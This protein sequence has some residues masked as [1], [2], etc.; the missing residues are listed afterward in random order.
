[1]ASFETFLQM[2][3][4]ITLEHFRTNSLHSFLTTLPSNVIRG[5]VLIMAHII[6]V[7]ASTAQVFDKHKHVSLGDFYVA[8][9]YLFFCQAGAAG[10]N[11][12]REC[13]AVWVDCTDLRRFCP[14]SHLFINVPDLTIN[15]RSVEMHHYDYYITP[16]VYL[17]APSYFTWFGLWLAGGSIGV[18]FVSAHCPVWWCQMLTIIPYPV[19][20][21]RIHKTS[22]DTIIV[23]WQSICWLPNETTDSL[24]DV[25]TI[26][27][28]AS[29]CIS[30]TWDC[31]AASTGK[32]NNDQ[33]Q[34]SIPI[35]ANQPVIQVHGLPNKSQNHG[36]KNIHSIQE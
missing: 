31:T 27:L 1:M 29:C 18:V 24:F 10:F 20:I 32:G 16:L 23:L 17:V 9:Y 30:I 6:L 19:T 33:S 36:S 14:F 25:Y 13:G 15:Q 21:I 35:I 5:Q 4:M 11:P 28:V 12:Y 2:T 7:E 3:F 34:P 22:Y 8:N 26:I